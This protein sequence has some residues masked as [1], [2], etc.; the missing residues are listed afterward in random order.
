MSKLGIYLVESKRDGRTFLSLAI[1]EN[2]NQVADMVAFRD[3]NPYES[4]DA[5]TG[6]G[7]LGDY[8]PGLVGHKMV[9]ANSVSG[10]IVLRM[11]RE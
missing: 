4:V 2:A 9:V 5:D 10:G 6:V 1:G 7:R 11:E 8:E 3:D